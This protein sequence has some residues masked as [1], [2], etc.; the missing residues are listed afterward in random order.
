MEEQY[1]KKNIGL[2]LSDNEIYK[3]YVY[4]MSTYKLPTNELVGHCFYNYLT[5]IPDID[6]E[7]I[8]FDTMGNFSVFLLADGNILIIGNMEHMDNSIDF[9]LGISPKYRRLIEVHDNELRNICI[10]RYIYTNDE[11]HEHMFCCICALDEN[12]CLHHWI[13][14]CGN[15]SLKDC[16][17]D[18]HIS[19]FAGYEFNNN[20]DYITFVH[21]YDAF[22]SL[23]IKSNNNFYVIDFDNNRILFNVYKVSE[24]MISCVIVKDEVINLNFDEEIIFERQDSLQKF[25]LPG[26]LYLYNTCDRIYAVINDGTSIFL[27][28]SLHTDIE[29]NLKFPIIF[30]IH[31]EYID[32]VDYCGSFHVVSVDNKLL[33]KS[34]NE[35][36]FS[37]LN[38]FDGR[39]GILKKKVHKKIK[40]ANF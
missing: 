10:S 23:L 2:F 14:E 35:N 33:V 17:I 31:R 38:H 5:P 22:F 13:F 8:S 15:V 9:T 18:H 36:D 6:Q 25:L 20:I 19:K 34:R 27:Y 7:V 26:I 1:F 21:K 37:L 40:N 29:E 32:G 11:D 16:R 24:N 3:P 39:P 30:Y 12:N 28:D 4:G